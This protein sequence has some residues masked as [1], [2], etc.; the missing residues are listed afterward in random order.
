MNQ[1]VLNIIKEPLLYGS[2]RTPDK[3]L[4]SV[5]ITA[6]KHEAFIE[7]CIQSILDQNTGFEYEI[8]LGEDDSNDGT[9]ELSKRLADENPDKIH[10]YLH[11]RENVIEVL[12]GKTGRFNFLY[13][14]SKA[15]GKYIALCD[16]DDYWT[17]PNKL[18]KQVDIL[19]KYPKVA[20]SAHEVKVWKNGLFSNPTGHKPKG[21]W[22]TILD[23]AKVNFIHTASCMYRN[24][25]QYPDWLLS[26]S[27]ADYPLHM[28][29]SERGDI[30]YSSD[31]MAAYRVHEGGVWSKQSQE[32]IHRRWVHQLLTMRPYFQKEVQE[33][34]DVQIKGF[35]A[36]ALKESH[37]AKK[38]INRK[39]F[40]EALASESE[41][42]REELIT[43]L[44]KV[45]SDTHVKRSALNA[46][47]LSREIKFSE[48]F[49]ALW[50]KVIKK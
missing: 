31:V 30:H 34:F 3:P 32:D 44:S 45:L 25:I 35:M 11:H 33:I 24:G 38:D 47:F 5:C 27:T 19:E 10:L 8:I 28:L 49:T 16:G 50:N 9:R 13:N 40:E 20:I 4:V 48:L 23:L 29:N 41:G 17:D 18:Q 15:T 37:V 39:W 22:N 36:V 2:P 12:G 1:L 6:Y 43:I 21:E 14:L 7:Q 42:A 26:T 46:D